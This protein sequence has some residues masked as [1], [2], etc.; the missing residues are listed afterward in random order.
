MCVIE[1]WLLLPAIS[2]I[3][4]CGTSKK[5]DD[6]DDDDDDDNND[7]NNKATLTIKRE[8]VGPRTTKRHQQILSTKGSPLVLPAFPTS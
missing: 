2:I 4:I 6:D 5:D 1:L 8:V 7:N 3:I